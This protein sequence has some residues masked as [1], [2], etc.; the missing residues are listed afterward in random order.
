MRLPLSSNSLLFSRAPLS[1]YSVLHLTVGFELLHPLEGV[2]IDDRLVF[3]FEPLATVVHFAQVYPVLEDV[4]EWTVSEGNAALDFA[5]FVF[6]RLVTM[7]RWSR[8][9]TNRP[10][11]FSLR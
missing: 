7:P 6:R 2:R 10:N 1:E 4:G 5:T 8:S 9:A 3:A 11:N